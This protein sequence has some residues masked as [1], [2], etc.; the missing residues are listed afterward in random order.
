M[1]EKQKFN[2]L[3]VLCQLFYP[4]L[5]STGQTIT[6][7]CEQLSD[8][9][10]DVEVV[11]APPSVI[12]PQE[13]VQRYMEHRG[14]RIKRVLATSFPKLNFTGRI[15]N[16]ITYALSVFIYLLF[17]RSKRPMLVLTNPPFLAFF[18]ALLRKLKIGNPYIYLIFDVYPDTAINLGVIKE[19]SLLSRLWEWVNKISF[20]YASNIIVIGR[21]MKDIIAAKINKNGIHVAGNKVQMIPVWSDDKYIQ[22]NKNDKN[23]FIE[24]WGLE[25]KFVVLYS[26]NMGRF[27]DMETI[28]GVTKEL[29]AFENIFFL[30]V[31][32]GHKKKWM[33]EYAQKHNIRNCQFHTYVN[34]EDLGDVLSCGNIGLVSLME[35]QEGLSVPSK[36]YALM[37]AGLPVIAVMSFSSEIAQMII[38]ENCGVV[39]RNGNVQGL[40]DTIVNLYNNQKH[41]KRLSINAQKTIAEKYNLG[42]ASDSYYKL[43]NE[44]GSLMR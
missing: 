14:I 9:G 32:E 2:K 39:V 23:P 30:F 16:Q 4:E 5:V 22:T 20:T 15:I 6:E 17:D 7:L 13:R 36:T 35:G 40:K 8:R 26:G 43:I 18:C 37:A 28:M 44:F 41:L 19:N 24:R 25:R 3:L 38:E 42:S 29:S 11:C 12:N 1:W 10:V 33:I 34:R 31:G 21:C 27:H